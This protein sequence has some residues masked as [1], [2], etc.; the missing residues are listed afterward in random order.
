MTSKIAEVLHENSRLKM[1]NDRLTAEVAALREDAEELQ[2]VVRKLAALIAWHHFGECRAWGTGQIISPH[3][4]DKLARRVLRVDDAARE[5]EPTNALRDV[6]A[7]RRRQ[8]EVEGWT[9]EHDDQHGDNSM[10]VAAACYALHN[11]APTRLLR[12]LWDW[13]GWAS[14]WFK[15]KDRR[16]N[17]VR[18]AALLIAQIERLDRDAAR[19]E[20]P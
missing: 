4:A 9:I 16:R 10:S 13:T 19:K 1:E 14:S 11:L 18:A 7:E 20:Q 15:P 8:I 12:A 3:E 6:A 5:S 17:L 2:T